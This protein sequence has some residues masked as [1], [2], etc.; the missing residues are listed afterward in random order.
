MDVERQRL[1]ETLGEDLHDADDDASDPGDGDDG[2]APAAGLGGDGHSNDGTLLHAWSVEG[3]LTRVGAWE[4][5]MPLAERWE[6][7]GLVLRVAARVVGS[8]RAQAEGHLDEAR[9]QRA[10]AAGQAFKRAHL[11]GA[12]VVGATRRLEALRA[13][14]PFAMVSSNVFVFM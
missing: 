11:I 2:G 8:L 13:A 9:R 10:E 1:L 4:W 6:A 12:T 3:A 7:A 5:S 14:E